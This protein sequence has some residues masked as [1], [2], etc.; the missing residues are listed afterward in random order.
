VT[1]G[2]SGVK[3]E[4][5]AFDGDSFLG[6]RGGAKASVDFVYL[7]PVLGK[8]AAVRDL[9]EVTRIV[10][11]PDG[12][13]VHFT[14]LQSKAREIVRARQVVLAAGTMNTLRLLFASSCGQDRIA[15]MPSLGKTFGT[16][17]DMS[18]FWFKA[19]AQPSSF[20]S[21][22]A[23][24]TFTV[25]GIDAPCLGM[26]GFPGVDTLPL[27]SA[28][29]RKLAGTVLVF[30]IGVDSGRASVGFDR[31]ALTVDY[32]PRREPIFDDIRE[33][34]RV[35]SAESGLKTWAM[36]KPTT[37]HPWGGASVGADADRGVVDHRGEVYGNPGLFIADA[38]ALPAAV[39]EPPSLAVAAWAHHVADG[40]RQRSAD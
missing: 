28:L 31:G 36:D 34:F 38:S 16:N 12:Y 37:V 4:A 17:G 9:C 10:R 24:G 11:E 13:A 40:V 23:L 5:C 29:K 30:G 26:G 7:A 2:A 3:R 32:D 6:S 8:G 33:A 21:P 35:L 25:A 14:D 20:R 1:Q 22:P 19:S 27:P 15:P 18:G 39:G